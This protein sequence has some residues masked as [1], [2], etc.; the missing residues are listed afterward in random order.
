MVSKS[1]RLWAKF[2]QSKRQ[3][4]MQQAGAAGDSKQAAVA[5][6]QGS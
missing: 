4:Q 6:K 1:E 5:R 2:L 3:Q